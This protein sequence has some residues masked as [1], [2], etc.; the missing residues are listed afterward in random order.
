MTE[1]EPGAEAYVVERGRLDV[2]RGA[3][4]DA[5]GLAS[6]GPGDWVGEMSLLLD[7]PRSAT[8]V[9]VTDAQLRR[10]SRHDMGHVLAEDP[11]QTEELLRQLA[12]RVKAANAVAAGR[13]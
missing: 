4:V 12:R 10:V 6:L 1:G 13:V 9:A 7:E 8:V 5:V 11:R 3:G 2:R